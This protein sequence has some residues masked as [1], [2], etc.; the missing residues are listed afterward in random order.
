[1]FLQAELFLVFWCVATALIILPLLIAVLNLK[2]SNVSNG[3]EYWQGL[4]DSMHITIHG[5]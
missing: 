4:V 2:F 3:A 1:M 5:S